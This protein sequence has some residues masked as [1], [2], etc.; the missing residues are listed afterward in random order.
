[1]S[2]GRAFDVFDRREAPQQT[3]QIL[4]LGALVVDRKNREPVG[5]HAVPTSS[6]SAVSPRRFGTLIT[7]VVPSP[8]SDSILSA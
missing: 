7:V 1:M 4:E 2:V 3:R 5:A 8:S 6:C